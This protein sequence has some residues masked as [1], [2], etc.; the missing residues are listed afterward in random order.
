M[1]MLQ[2]DQGTQTELFASY[3][4]VGS[5]VQILYSQRSMTVYALPEHELH[6][7]AMANTLAAAFFSIGTG[8]MF[9]VLGIIVNGLFTE[10]PTAENAAMLTVIKWAA[11]IATGICYS[12]GGWA[13]YNRHSIVSRI[14][15]ESK[16]LN[17][18]G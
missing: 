6:S 16:T 9:F 17:P 4:Q 14:K 10:P 15:R 12:L 8:T 1:S 11:S 7:V 18:P 3:A 2:E 13:L 5:A